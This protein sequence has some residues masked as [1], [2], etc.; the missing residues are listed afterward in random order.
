MIFAIDIGNTNIKL[1]IFDKNQ[2]IENN[3]FDSYSE[4][5]NYIIKKFNKN[6]SICISSVVPKLTKKMKSNHL[7]SKNLF[8]VKHT[9]CKLKLNIDF[10]ESV[11]TDRLCNISAA[12]K[13][14][15][16]PMII[17]DFGTANT[18]N[19]IDENNTFIGGI[20]APGIK[21]S[22][23]CLA[24]KGAQL[25]KTPFIFPKNIIGKS[26]EKNIQSGIM[27]GTLTQTEGIIE[28]I[29]KETNIKNY[30][31]ILTGGFGKIIS[32]KLTFK[33][34]Y[35]QNLTLRGLLNIYNNNL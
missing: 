27:Y 6:D 32:K 26:T 14:Y 17:I 25:N 10:P 11:G 31:I 5:E 13:I 28:K 29:K 21:T 33:H 23:Q 12:T 20:I 1:G 35:D 30:S 24:D 22:S 2:L 15:K 18:Y 9:N 19:V 4:F 8:L 7:L 34:I 16:S 3:A